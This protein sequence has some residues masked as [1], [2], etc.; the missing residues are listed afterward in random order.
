M[1][2]SRE[3]GRSTRYA[4]GDTGQHGMK[5][6]NTGQHGTVYS[7]EKCAG[8]N[9]LS[10]AKSFKKLIKITHYVKNKYTKYS[11]SFLNCLL[12]LYRLFYKSR[13]GISQIL[14]ILKRVGRLF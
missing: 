11:F 14:V 13:Q 12:I 5:L 3:I 6:R 9:S 7:W 1:V 2:C 8:I 4:A 10:P